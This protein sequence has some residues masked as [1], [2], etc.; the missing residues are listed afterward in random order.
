M[1]KFEAPEMEISKF[2]IADVLTTSDETLPTDMTD[3]A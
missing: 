2:E 1:K 3:L